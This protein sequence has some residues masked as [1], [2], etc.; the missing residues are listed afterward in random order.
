MM[1]CANDYLEI[2][3]CLLD[4]PTGAA[5]LNRRDNVGRTA[6]WWAAERGSG[7]VVS[8]MGSNVYVFVALTS[9]ETSFD[10]QR[11]V[12]FPCWQVRLLL[13]RG[14]DPTIACNN[15]FTPMA[16]AK[17]RTSNASRRRGRRKCIKA[18]EVSSFRRPHLLEDH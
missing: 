7:E 14:A 11:R 8:P 1:P 10:G 6:A 4:H 15:G 12:S 13:E 17:E 3:R 2:V 5:T 18:L 16:L 9:A